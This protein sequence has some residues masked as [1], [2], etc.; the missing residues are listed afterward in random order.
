M[1]RF[2]QVLTVC[3]C[4]YLLYVVKSALGI[5]ISPQYH[6][7]DLVRIPVRYVVHKFTG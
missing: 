5:D 3:L 4:L 7:I 1:Q 6:A 2:Q